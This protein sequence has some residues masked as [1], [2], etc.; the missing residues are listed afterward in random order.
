[1]RKFIGSPKYENLTD[2]EFEAFMEW[3]SFQLQKRTIIRYMKGEWLVYG[4]QGKPTVP[5]NLTIHQ[6]LEY[7]YYEVWKIDQQRRIN[8]GGRDADIHSGRS[9]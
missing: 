4:I 1:M 2:E 7:W 9:N 5:H 6:I 3:F 8:R